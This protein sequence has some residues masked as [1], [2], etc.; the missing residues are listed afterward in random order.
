MFD[1]VDDSVL[2]LMLNDP[3]LEGLYGGRVNRDEI[4]S[5]LNDPVAEPDWES[6]KGITVSGETQERIMVEMEDDGMAAWVTLGQPKE[7]EQKVTEGELRVALRTNHIVYG[8]N[9]S[10]LNR[11]VKNPVYQ[12]AFIIAKG[13]APK[14][15]TDGE[16]KYYFDTKKELR[17]MEQENGEIN[18]REINFVQSV[19][20][21]DLLCELILGEPGTDG[22][23]VTGEPLRARGGEQSRLPAGRN[24]EISEDKM[25]L[26]AGCDGEVSYKNK[27]VHVDRVLYVDN[28]DLSTGNIR[29][30]GSVHVRG[31]VCE[32]FSLKAT[33][34]ITV[35]EVIEGA[36]VSA[37][38]N[39]RV[40]RGIKGSET[41]SIRA[42]QN[43]YAPFV[44]NMKVT[45]GGDIYT[46]VLFNSHVECQGKITAQGE[47]GY[48]LGGTSV[49][50]EVEATQIG[51]EANVPTN[52]EIM[53]LSEMELE[54]DDLKVEYNMCER[55]VTKLQ[56][57]MQDPENPDKVAAQKELLAAVYKKNETGRKVKEL[58]A[59]ITQLRDRYD[60]DVKIKETIYPNVGIRIE[61]EV[62]RNMETVI[63]CVFFRMGNHIV[64][65]SYSK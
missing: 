2:D 51:N 35:N 1:R 15:G 8:I 50:Y 10:V 13:R 37:G 33:E 52:I 40:Q 11:L 20:K 18:F 24:T 55:T 27:Q 30:I 14:H 32:G 43:L 38:G 62:T 56:K 26:Y 25:R 64:A 22:I 65:R 5:I 34:N 31:R 59:K 49:A 36:E 23:S 57:N 46:S 48:I 58:D 39:I 54:V 45:V 4:R 47:K 53:G 29:H 60:F 6:K 7:D 21:G 61:G 44:E 19:S 28:I 41:G 12:K 9:D 63:G 16:I 42:G 17:P 3:G